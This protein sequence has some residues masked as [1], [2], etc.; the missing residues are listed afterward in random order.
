MSIYLVRSLIPSIA[1]LKN[2]NEFWDVA[3]LTFYSYQE[4]SLRSLINNFFG[5]K[6]NLREFTAPKYNINIKICTVDRF[7]GHEADIVFL[8]FVKTHNV[9]F[10][11]SLNRLNVAITR[12][13]YQLVMIGN[14]KFFLDQKISPTLKELAKIQD[15]IK[16]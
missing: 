7:Q 9:G 16:C 14:K 11:N 10:L 5:R 12:A 2:G 8:S 1:Y 13:R 6:V 3:V 15:D 4:D